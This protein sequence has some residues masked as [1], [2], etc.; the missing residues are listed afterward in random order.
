MFEKEMD[1]TRGAPPAS[2][3]PVEE[4]ASYAGSA[5]MKNG[6]QLGPYTGG[7]LGYPALREFF[8]KKSGIPV[9]NIFL[10]PGGMA[11]WLWNLKARVSKR[12]SATGEFRP[13]TVGMTKLVYDRA[14]FAIEE[15]NEPLAR[16]GIV[17]VK[18]V[19][20]TER[21]DGI[22]LG[23]L[24]VAGDYL[25]ELY[26]VPDFSNPTAA[27]WSQSNRLGVIDL[28]NRFGFRIAE[29]SPYPGLH[30]G[31]KPPP[32]I[33]DL[34][35]QDID[36]IFQMNS[37]SKLFN[38]AGMRICWSTTDNLMMDFLKNQSHPSCP[39]RIFIS[40][41]ILGALVV[42]HLLTENSDFLTSKPAQLRETLGPVV[43]EL[44]EKIVSK[45]GHLVQLHTVPTGGYFL[46]F[47]IITKNWNAPRL[48]KAAKEKANL[49]LQ[50]G[51]P[52]HGNQNDPD[53]DLTIRVAFPGII[54]AGGADE[55]IRRML[56]AFGEE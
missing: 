44:G 30:Y 20:I 34:S 32:S 11:A 53:V 28:A 24:E 1:A 55:F 48:I 9:D 25:D 31:E 42:E 15:I 37:L 33:F 12:I 50:A 54:D 14:R 29:D 26:T 16:F 45:L 51:R 21:A 2:L 4:L 35:G 23:E 38:I 39:A 52:F 46:W 36:L 19:L 7:A 3:S 18:T 6:Q 27:V 22:D 49:K 13:Y 5:I 8:A 40:Q 56:V 41:P 10:S 43:I 47:K 17:P